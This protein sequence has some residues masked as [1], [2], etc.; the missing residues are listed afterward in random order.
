M[1][2]EEI[3]KFYISC[4]CLHVSHAKLFRGTCRY[5]YCSLILFKVC[6]L[7]LSSHSLTKAVTQITLF[8]KKREI[9]IFLSFTGLNH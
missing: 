1:I 7:L 3:F 2:V 6:S 9:V 8:L 4:I 5:Y